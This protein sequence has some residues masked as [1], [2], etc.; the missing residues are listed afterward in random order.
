M[1]IL[2]LA[3]HCGHHYAHHQELKS[4]IQWL[5]PVVFRAVIL[6]LLVWCGAEGYVSSLQDA[7]ATG[8]R[9]RSCSLCFAAKY[10]TIT[11][12]CKE[13]HIEQYE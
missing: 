3:Q 6:K 9:R 8:H 12:F 1:Q 13:L 2:S 11:T 5:L 4:I 10:V 7:A